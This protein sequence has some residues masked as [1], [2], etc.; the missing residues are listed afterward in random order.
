MYNRE[1]IYFYIFTNGNQQVWTYRVKEIH[2]YTLKSIID[3][4]LGTPNVASTIS[5]VNHIFNKYELT[6]HA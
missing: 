4:V 3:Y 1:M 2:S 6:D 5:D